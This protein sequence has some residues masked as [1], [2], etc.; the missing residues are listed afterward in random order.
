MASWCQPS[1]KSR[2][3]TA[4]SR[5][6]RKL[7][8]FLSDRL[9]ARH[10]TILVFV[11]D[12][13]RGW[14]AHC[15]REAI[16]SQVRSLSFGGEDVRMAAMFMG[17]GPVYLTRRKR[18]RLSHKTDDVRLH[19][20]FRCTTTRCPSYAGCACVLR[21]CNRHFCINAEPICLAVSASKD[22]D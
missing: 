19:V 8:V 1:C 16:T 9:K 17:S 10:C 4:G 15:R 7:D 14:C 2:R 18:T 6:F 22:V 13:A 5:S 11:L 3:R 12:D 20:N 21:P